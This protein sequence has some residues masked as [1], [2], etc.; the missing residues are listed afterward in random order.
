MNTRAFICGMIVGLS[1]L[2]IL[3]LLEA[4]VIILREPLTS[5]EADVG[6]QVYQVLADARRILDE[7][8]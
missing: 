2:T 5:D 8:A 4:A 3:G 7:A 6:D 1:V